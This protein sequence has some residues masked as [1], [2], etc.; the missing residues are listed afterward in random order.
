MSGVFVTGTDTGIGKTT[1]AVAL[2]HAWRL[3]G[4]RVVGMKPVAAGG[5]L[6]DGVWRNDDTAALVAASSVV[7]D[8]RLVTPYAFAAPIAPHIAAAQAGVTIDI[9]LIVSAYA[10]LAT[11]ADRVVVE[12]VG[13]WCVPLGASVDTADMAVALGLPVVLVVGMR[14]GCL[15]HA[16]LTSE[17]IRRRGLH[18]AGW[19][20]NV[21][22]PTMTALEDN[23]ATLYARLDAACLGVL[24]YC[25]DETTAVDV[26]RLSLDALTRAVGPD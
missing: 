16:L 18:L 22:D 20:A 25:A 4:L 14:L 26:A 21:L 23:L 19:V 1:V 10:E 5:T 7:A 11:L 24:P 9:P 13:G 2:I 17:A 6:V 3:R 15:N 12:G 8:S